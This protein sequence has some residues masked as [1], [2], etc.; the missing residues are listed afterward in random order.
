MLQVVPHPSVFLTEQLL[1]GLFALD[2]RVGAQTALSLL[3]NRPLRGLLGLKPDRFMIPLDRLKANTSDRH[4]AI[5][6]LFL[7]GLP[8]RLKKNPGFIPRDHSTDELIEQLN[9]R[10]SLA[11]AF[12][13]QVVSRTSC[14]SDGRFL[15]LLLNRVLSFS[16]AVVAN[17]LAAIREIAPDKALLAAEGAFNGVR[18]QVVADFL[19]TLGD[20]GIERLDRLT[21]KS[22]YEGCCVFARAMVHVSPDQALDLLEA[23]SVREL[24]KRNVAADSIYELLAIELGWSWP[25]P[26]TAERMDRCRDICTR[27]LEDP[28][29]SIR[30]SALANLALI[31]WPD[32]ESRAREMLRD[33]EGDARFEALNI[34]DEKDATFD[35]STTTTLLVDQDEFVRERM[36]A[37]VRRLASDPRTTLSR[38]SKLCTSAHVERRRQ[39]VDWVR[40]LGCQEG[41]DLLGRMARDPDPEV[42]TKATVAGFRISSHPTPWLRLIRS[43]LRDKVHYVRREMIAILGECGQAD[44]F[45]RIA[46]ALADPDEGTRIAALAAATKLVPQCGVELATKL[47][48]DHDGSVASAAFDKLSHLCGSDE[49]AAI[50]LESIPQVRGDTAL[51]DLAKNRWPAR[52]REITQL[53]LCS[54]NDKVRTWGIAALPVEASTSHV[55]MLK[56]ML[57]EQSR[58][59]RLAVVKC[60]RRLSPDD[61]SSIARPRLADADPRVR[62]ETLQ[63]LIAQGCIPSIAE[64][65]QL[66]RDESPGVRSTALRTLSGLDD[67][68]VISELVSSLSDVHEGIRRLAQGILDGDHG[69]VPSVERMERNASTTW[70]EL[71]ARVA[72]INKWAKQ[73]G[74]EL[75]GRSVVVWN[76]RQGLGRTKVRTRGPVEIEVSDTP[77]T[78]CHPHGEEVM[79]GLVLHELGHHVCDFT[80]RGFKTADGIARSEGLDQLWNVLLDE[81]LERAL[82]SRRP[83]WG[84]YFDRLSSYVFAQPPRTVPLRQYAELLDRSAE[85]TADAVRRGELPGNY[86]PEP[87]SESEALISMTA[88]EMLTI[89]RLVPPFIAF[90]WCLRSGFDPR[91]C[92]D[93]KVRDAI[94][95]VPV[96]LKDIPHSELL[97]VARRVAKRLPDSKTTKTQ[98]IQLRRRIEKSPAV[99]GSLREVLDRLAATRQLPDW[100]SEGTPAIRGTLEVPNERQSC[101]KPIQS[102]TLRILGGR[103]LN[104]GKD[105]DYRPLEHETAVIFDRSRHLELVDSIR[106]HVRRLRP[107]FERL[108]TR[109]VTNYG[110]R[111]GR[112]LDLG[113]IRTATLTGSPDFLIQRHDERA[114]SAYLGVLIDRSASMSNERMERA[115]RFGALV[116]EAAGGLAG[117][118]GHVNAFDDN[119]FY[120]MG[121]LKRN[122]IACLD[123]GGGNNDS[124]A[125]EKAAELALASRKQNKLLIMIS[126]GSPSGCTFES[127]KNLVRKLTREQGIDCVQV[128]VAPLSHIAFPRSVDLSRFEL[129]EAVARFGK[130]LIQLTRD[131]R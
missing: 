126:D 16:P 24:V 96:N 131:W 69:A 41:C 64:L 50:V 122:A 33:P 114:P 102:T 107:Y 46:P 48:T 72:T 68:R 121:D 103:G 98:T 82:R 51:L 18:R 36:F 6:C 27:L 43:R 17:C 110:S 31:D 59:I 14:V 10:D 91:A 62:L 113:R 20:P 32:W 34:L 49:F 47:L 125:L 108:G 105:R 92:A 101:D 109:S 23:W 104:L 29:W 99:L 39:I 53:A 111:H 85:E 60:L 58:D 9:S 115:R 52:L 30:A 127:L 63:G 97:Q 84:I 38:I 116:A 129:D 112:H 61:F 119:T 79:R 19:V 37:R 44:D 4:Q 15:P 77:V 3:A 56:D 120:R 65:L 94:A 12:A 1:H 130:M 2:P 5:A 86:I 42:R 90:L 75:L 117:I 95:L 80:V 100:R 22:Q 93:R 118:E 71:V 40:E 88:S 57:R 87:D 45:D 78:T 13:A 73:I 7:E 67:G 81:R 70:R 55:P 28:A 106:K 123:A 66:A 74:R 128:A 11:Q 21:N 124:A 25:T 89:P 35:D 54:R 8:A 83:E 76:Y 26:P